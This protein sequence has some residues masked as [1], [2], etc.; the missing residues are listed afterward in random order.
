MIVLLI[1]VSGHKRVVE[2]PHFLP[3]ICVP[4]PVRLN[5]DWRLMMVPPEPTLT[6]FAEFVYSTEL[7]YPPVYRQ[8]LLVVPPKEPR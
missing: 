5:A 6:L 8:K 1:D 3:V 4:L 2:I 7:S